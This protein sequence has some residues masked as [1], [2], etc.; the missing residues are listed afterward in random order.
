VNLKLFSVDFRV[1]KHALVL[2]KVV[3]E[4]VKDGELFVETDQCVPQVFVIYDERAM[5]EIDFTL[6]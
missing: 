2:L 4:V 5:V 1:F 3:L 6:S